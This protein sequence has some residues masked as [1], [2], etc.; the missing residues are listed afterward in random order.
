VETSKL[1]GLLEYFMPSRGALLCFLFIKKKEK[2]YEI[3]GGNS[4]R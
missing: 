1:E 4:H 3:V 2:D